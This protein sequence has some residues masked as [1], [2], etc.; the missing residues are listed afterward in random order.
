M[1]VLKWMIIILSGLL[2]SYMVIDGSRGLIIGDYIRPESG[3]YAGQLGPWAD[4]VSAININ[5][6]SNFMKW[7]FLL[8]GAI[9]LFIMMAFAMKVRD[10]AKALLI[11][12]FLS[13][14]YLMV[15]TAMGVL[16]CILLLIYLS[17]ERKHELNSG[18]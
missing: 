8:W 14:W 18:V 4:L 16:I 2:Y 11:L 10:A 1:K 15:G 7:T 5:P 13:L 12:T 17:R 6:E 3:E 9:G